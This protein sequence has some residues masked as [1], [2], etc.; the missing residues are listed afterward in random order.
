MESTVCDFCFLRSLKQ[1]R[2][3]FKNARSGFKPTFISKVFIQG[4]WYYR[5][6]ITTLSCKAAK[7]RQSSVDSTTYRKSEKHTRYPLGII[8]YV[9]DFFFQM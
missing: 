6:Y 1:E 7:I 4:Q 2:Q 8:K 5:Y 9:R 3:P